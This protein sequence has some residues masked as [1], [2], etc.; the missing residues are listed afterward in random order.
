MLFDI[1][2][3]YGN[4]YYY[5][6]GVEQALIFYVRFNQIMY[7]ILFVFLSA[8]YCKYKKRINANRNE[9]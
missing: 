7:G 1:N 8:L 5:Q 2:W 3:H 9:A 6:V 4:E